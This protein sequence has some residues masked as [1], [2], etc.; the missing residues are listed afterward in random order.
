M[1]NTTLTAAQPNMI[2]RGL[3]FDLAPTPEQEVQFRQNAGVVRLV[4][5]L[6]L[7]QRRDHWRAYH[8]AHGKHISIASQCRELTALR[9]QHD[10]I[11]NISITCQQQA[12]RDLDRAYS[13]FFKGIAA[14]PAPRRKGLGDS[15]RFQGREIETRKL[16]RRWSEVRLPK[17]GWIRYRDT[18]L[19]RGTLKNVTVSHD[20]LGWRVSFAC[21]I[22]HDVPANDLPSV[23]ID[24]GV[25][26]TLALDT[27][28]LLSL[29]IERLSVLDRRHRKAQRLQ[30]RRKRGSKRHA[31]ARQQANRIKA[32]VARIRRDW[33]HKAALGIA[34]RFGTVVLEDLR[35]G[36]MTASAA[37]TVENPGTNV[38]QKRGLNRSILNQG[39]HQFEV[40]LGYKLEERGGRLVKVDPSWTSRTC[41]ACGAVHHANR[42]N[43]AEFACLSCGVEEHADINAARVIKRRGSTPLLRMEAGHEAA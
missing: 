36:N 42:K 22:E 35:I 20:A 32:K 40:L 16:N 5:N 12:L 31:K 34:R 43:Q 9:A 41:S 13:N 23:G 39:W 28:E 25:A 38:A 27:G 3:R 7:E 21:M 37:G 30:A 2:A 10:W 6:A 14:Y 11:A 19:I 24:R 33:H 26:N 17:I 29:P 18:R 4:Y 1:P 8:R 15:F